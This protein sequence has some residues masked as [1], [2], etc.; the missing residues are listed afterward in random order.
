MGCARRLVCFASPH[1]LATA[2]DVVAHTAGA[3]GPV[4]SWTIRVSW[5][6]RRTRTQIQTRLQILSLVWFR[7][8]VQQAAAVLPWPPCCVDTVA[9]VAVSTVQTSTV[10]VDAFD[11]NAEAC[12]WVPTVTHGCT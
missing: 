2:V 9:I 7:R 8:R 11:C 3:R 4:S 5:T 12:V 6:I 1:G 10:P